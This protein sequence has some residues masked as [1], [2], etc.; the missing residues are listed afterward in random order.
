MRSISLFLLGLF[1]SFSVYADEV[2]QPVVYVWLDK[3]SAILASASGPMLVGAAAVIEVVLR[4]WKSDKPLSILHVI[5]GGAR[6]LGDL[7]VKLADILDKVLPQ[8]L[9]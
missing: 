5:G 6:K 9:A 7:L 1:V 4:L 3:V 2:A 8:R